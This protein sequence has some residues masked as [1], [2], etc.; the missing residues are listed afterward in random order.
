MSSIF[1]FPPQPSAFLMAVLMVAIAFRLAVA[2]VA[3]VGVEQDVKRV[4]NK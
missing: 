4:G 1:F 3:L 2:L